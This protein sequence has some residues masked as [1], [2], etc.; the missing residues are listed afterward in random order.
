MAC[1]TVS[2]HWCRLG[3]IH[4]PV[5]DEGFFRAWCVGCDHRHDYRIGTASEEDDF[6]QVFR[7]TVHRRQRRF[8]RLGGPHRLRR[9]SSRSRFGTL[10][11]NE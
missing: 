2:G 6:F 8:N 3:G 11:G 9:W 1:N 4:D 10:A 5:D 7:F